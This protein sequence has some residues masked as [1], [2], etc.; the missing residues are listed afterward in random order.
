MLILALGSKILYFSMWCY[1]RGTILL[2]IVVQVD[3]IVSRFYMGHLSMETKFN[4]NIGRVMSLKWS[5]VR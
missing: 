1:K 4:A 5:H 3:N 2:F